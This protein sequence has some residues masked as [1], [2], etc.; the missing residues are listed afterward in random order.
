VGAP[1]TLRLEAAAAG[2]ELVRLQQRVIHQAMA[3]ALDAPGIE[4]RPIQ[5]DMTCLL[6]A[7]ACVL[8]PHASTGAI[9][10]IAPHPIRI[11]A[12][13]SIA[14]APATTGVAAGREHASGLIRH[15]AGRPGPDP[16][17]PGSQL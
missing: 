10:I 5:L 2:D 15:R 17:Q 4:A 16:I 9:G 12:E 8:M 1:A 14:N 11:L 6:V 3:K 13:R 7:H